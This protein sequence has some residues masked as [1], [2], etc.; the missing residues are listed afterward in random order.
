[1]DT[2]QLA[3]QRL[4]RPHLNRESKAYSLLCSYSYGALYGAH[5]THLHWLFA[6]EHYYIAKEKTYYKWVKTVT[7]SSRYSTRMEDL[8]KTLKV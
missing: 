8:L 3:A 2:L 4:L 6:N 5:P 1:M 7:F